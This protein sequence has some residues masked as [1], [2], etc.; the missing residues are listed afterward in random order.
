[1]LTYTI[2]GTCSSPFFG[3]YTI[4]ILHCNGKLC[5]LLGYYVMLITTATCFRQDKIQLNLLQQYKLRN[6]VL[7]YILY[8]L[9]QIRDDGLLSQI[10]M[11]QVYAT[12]LRG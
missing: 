11:N 6:S 5:T 12:R 8:Y 3:L 9:D 10:N 1:M 7:V 2:I 4:P